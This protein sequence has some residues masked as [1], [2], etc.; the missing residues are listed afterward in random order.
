MLD[1]TAFTPSLPERRSDG[2]LLTR[3]FRRIEGAVG[4]R[5]ARARRVTADAPGGAATIVVERGRVLKSNALARCWLGPA[6]RRGCGAHRLRAAIA[7][8][9]VALDEAVHRLIAKGV[10][11]DRKARI[12]NVE[13]RVRGGVDGPRAILTITPLP[14]AAPADRPISAAQPCGAPTALLDDRALRDMCDALPMGVAVFGSDKRLAMANATMTAML[15]SVGETVRPNPPLRELLGALRDARMGPEDGDH[16]ALL[17]RLLGL[18][19]GGEPYED[20][21]QFADGRVIQVVAKPNGDGGAVMMWDDVSVSIDMERWRRRTLKARDVTLSALQDGVAEF[22]PDGALA[23]ANVAFHRLW[24]LDEAAIAPG[25]ARLADVEAATNDLDPAAQAWR[26]LRAAVAGADVDREARVRIALGDRRILEMRMARL[27]DGAVLATFSDVT[28]SERIAD[29]LRERAIFLE[30]ADAMRS[31]ALYEI[32]HGLRTPLGSVIGNA[33]L[34]AAAA[35]PPL[36]PSQ[37]AYVAGIRDG[38][39]ALRGG[40]ASLTDLVAAGSPSLDRLTSDI[41]LGPLL[42]S[43]LALLRRRMAACRVRIDVSDAPRDAQVNG[44]PA[45]VRHLVFAML[46]EVIERVEAGGAA[47]FTARCDGGRLTLRARGVDRDPGAPVSR[48][49]ETAIRSARVIGAEL[50]LT[51]HPDGGV[52]VRLAMNGRDAG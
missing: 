22:G 24:R 50:A 17:D 6:I 31:A 52:E 46:S 11:F 51:E 42:R 26:P 28:D 33:D 3:L 29:A 23:T 16:R 21:W 32:S 15:G 13:R 5:A 35:D 2:S 12:S 4:G 10:A 40:V 38:A 14:A 36:P 49:F 39:E 9:D 48:G 30:A 8:E 19:D 27:P 45:R 25:A 7:A 1:A 20:I 34:L 41:A 37:A 43:A 18:F 44:D 47:A